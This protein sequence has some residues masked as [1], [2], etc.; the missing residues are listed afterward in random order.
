MVHCLNQLGSSQFGKYSAGV[1]GSK[2]DLELGLESAAEADYNGAYD[3]RAKLSSRGCWHL[4][5]DGGHVDV[6]HN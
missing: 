4:E 6:R 5:G 2:N 1:S 3:A